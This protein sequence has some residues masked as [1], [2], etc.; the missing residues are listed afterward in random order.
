MVHPHNG[1]LIAWPLST[2]CGGQRR[3]CPIVT[4]MEKWPG[5]EFERPAGSEQ[6]VWV[7]GPLYIVS[8]FPFAFCPSLHQFQSWLWQLWGKSPTQAFSWKVIQPTRHCALL[9][10][11]SNRLVNFFFT[12]ACRVLIG[13]VLK[14]ID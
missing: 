1:I 13:I 11:F 8:F 9:F 7:T 5:M 2:E 6:R 4:D 14:S 12:K 3:R 10:K